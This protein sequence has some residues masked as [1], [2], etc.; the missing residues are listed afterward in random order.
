MWD[1]FYI[2]FF[3]AQSP[4]QGEGGLL[5]E[6]MAPCADVGGRD[7]GAPA[8]RIR[9]LQ[10]RVDKKPKIERAAKNFLKC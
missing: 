1:E 4:C 3:E 7:G 6:G 10:T 5:H 8:P 9:T 2:R